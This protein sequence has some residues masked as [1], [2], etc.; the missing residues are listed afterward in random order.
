MI[1]LIRSEKC[2]SFVAII[3]IMIGLI[4]VIARADVIVLRFVH[5]LVPIQI[6]A[7]S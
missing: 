5:D 3:V 1:T 2:I 6:M 7:V 4:I